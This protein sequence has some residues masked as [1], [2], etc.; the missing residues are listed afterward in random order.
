MLLLFIKEINRILHSFDPPTKKF[1]NNC[2]TGLLKS[3]T[4]ADFQK[5]LKNDTPEGN[6][7]AVLEAGSRIRIDLMRI[8]IR[9]RIQHFF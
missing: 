4:S 2:K 3:L 9:I 6:A 8:R 1:I 7:F 5:K